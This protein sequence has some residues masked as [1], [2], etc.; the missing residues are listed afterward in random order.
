MATTKYNPP[1]QQSRA[2]LRKLYGTRA[3]DA[4]APQSKADDTPSGRFQ[5]ARDMGMGREQAA[6][7]RDSAFSALFRINP[8]PAQPVVAGELPGPV[9]DPVRPPANALDA[10]NQANAMGASSGTFP[11]PEYGGSVSFRR[12]SLMP[13]TP[14]A[15]MSEYLGGFARSDSPLSFFKPK[16]RPSILTG[17]QQWVAN[18]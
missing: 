2:A 14:T 12:P 8:R 3:I 7:A 16:P 17:A 9:M 10:I 5:F 1:Y 11:V 15:D 13:S 18:I 4:S 6:A